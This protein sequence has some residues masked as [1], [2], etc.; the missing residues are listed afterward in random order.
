MRAPIRLGASFGWTSHRRFICLT[1][2]QE[3]GEVYSLLRESELDPDEYID[4]HVATG[5]ERQ[6]AI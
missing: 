4:R 3:G 5:T 6:G 1:A 2:L